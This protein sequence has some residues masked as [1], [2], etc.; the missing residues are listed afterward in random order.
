MKWVWVWLLGEVGVV[1]GRGRWG[2]P[3]ARHW[4]AVG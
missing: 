4:V 2:S 3:R 1:L